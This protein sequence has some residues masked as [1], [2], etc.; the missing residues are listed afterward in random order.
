MSGIAA[1]QPGAAAGVRKAS[2]LHLLWVPDATCCFSPAASDAQ[3]GG[4][5]HA[6]KEMSSRR[7]GLKTGTFALS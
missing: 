7:D 2:S 6:A 4:R 1:E 5:G 3:Y